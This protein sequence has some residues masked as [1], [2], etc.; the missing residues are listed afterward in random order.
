[1]Y[2]LTYSPLLIPFWISIFTLLHPILSEKNSLF[3]TIYQEWWYNGSLCGLSP[4]ASVSF[5]EPHFPCG[6][7]PMSV[8]IAWLCS[9]V[10]LLIVKGILG[11]RSKGIDCLM[12]VRSVL[13]ISP[14]VNM[15]TSLSRTQGTRVYMHVCVRARGRVCVENGL[16]VL[17]SIAAT[18][19]E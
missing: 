7:I 9:S 13:F 5:P 12:D 3:E 2:V 1:M 16:N 15:W 6:P 17:F 8:E 18:N 14:M 10:S 19:P 4:A 11:N